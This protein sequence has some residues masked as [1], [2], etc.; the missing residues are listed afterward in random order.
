MKRSAGVTIA[1]VL[2]LAGS[3]LALLS[4][5]FALV[6]MVWVSIATGEPALPRPVLALMVAG[7]V[8]VLGVEVFGIF[9]AIGLLRLKNWARITTIVFAIL[10]ILSSFGYTLIF[11]LTPWSSLPNA[12]PHVD[13]AM[14]A[15]AATFG[16]FFLSVGVWWLVLLT[17]RSVRTQFEAAR[18]TMPTQAAS[19][20]MPGEIA[21]SNVPLPLV[22]PPPPPRPGRVPVVIIVVAIFL[23]A[24]APSVLLIPFLHFPAFFLGKILYG[25]AAEIFLFANVAVNVT[26]GICLLRL[27]SWSLP[28]TVAFYIFGL[29]N[30]LPMFLPARR[31]A[32]FAAVLRVMPMPAGRDMPPNVTPLSPH[33]MG[34]FAAFGAAFGALI[35]LTLVVLL[36][37]ARPAFD[38]AARERAAASA[39]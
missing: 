13:V 14:R 31:E 35:T 10:T 38:Q 36:L 39:A 5:I 33:M 8:M 2:L 20:A 34:Y 16:L 4:H 12:P 15:T 25:R 26:L 9:T 22:L 1:A 11:F 28:G 32:Y 21:A 24:G 29:L 30:S 27:K 37:R 6:T 18:S 23:L 19:P 7:S 17:R 3:S